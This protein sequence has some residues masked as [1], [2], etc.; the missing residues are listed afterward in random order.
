[1]VKKEEIYQNCPFAELKASDGSA[2]IR[3]CTYRYQFPEATNK[4][5]ADWYMNYILLNING[6][7]AEIDKPIIEGRVLTHLLEELIKFKRN[8]ISDIFSSFTEP[9]INFFLSNDLLIDKNIL[10]SGELIEYKV[11][12]NKAKVKFEFKTNLALLEKFITGIQRILEM[13]PSRYY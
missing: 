5:D 3:I 1:M 8:E 2:R 6:I 9:E 13:F 4:W 7:S 10:V 12:A 11:N